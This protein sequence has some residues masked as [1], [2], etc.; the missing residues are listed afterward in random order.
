[1]TSRGGGLIQ[2]S[3]TL[4]LTHCHQVGQGERWKEESWKTHDW[5]H[6]RLIGEAKTAHKSREKPENCSHFLKSS[7]CSATFLKSKNPSHGRATWEDMHHAHKCPLFL[8]LHLQLLLLSTML[9]GMG[10][11]S[12]RLGSATLRLSLPFLFN[13]CGAEWKAE[14][15]MWAFLSDSWDFSTLSGLLSTAPLSASRQV[16]LNLLQ[17]L[18]TWAYWSMIHSTEHPS[19]EAFSCPRRDQEPGEGTQPTRE[20]VQFILA[21]CLTWDL[22]RHTCKLNILFPGQVYQALKVQLRWLQKEWRAAKFFV[23]PR[24]LFLKSFS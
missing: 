8:F 6:N 11:S 16:K 1:M 19:P 14:N 15:G 13:A 3:L 20:L 4:L 9:C 2:L 24:Y 22:D 23:R 18:C 17:D 10:Y 7:R 21:M 5:H 12:G